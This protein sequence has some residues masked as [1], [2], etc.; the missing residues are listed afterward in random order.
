MPLKLWVP[1]LEALAIAAAEG[2]TREQLIDAGL[3]GELHGLARIR[4]E[5]GSA[6]PLASNASHGLGRFI[7]L[8]DGLLHVL[9][10]GGRC[11][12]EADRAWGEI[13]W[14]QSLVNLWLVLPPDALAIPAPELA[15][16]EFDAEGL[17]E[18]LGGTA[19]PAAEAAAEPDQDRKPGRSRLLP[20]ETVGERRLAMLERGRSIE[21]IAEHDDVD[22]DVVERSIRRGRHR[23]GQ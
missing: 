16:V 17:R 1:G 15:R 3:A 2:V 12:P 7:R 19:A 18:R 6:A 11:W 21:Q 23:R 4:L 14:G 20:G 10:P 9:H 5:D 22:I 13:N 8:K